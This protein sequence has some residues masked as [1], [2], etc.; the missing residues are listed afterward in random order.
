LNTG[1]SRS[2]V[3]VTGVHDNGSNAAASREQSR[4]ANFHGSSDDAVGC[5]QRG[6]SRTGDGLRQ[7]QVW[8]A[9]DLNTGGNG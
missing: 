3:G 5:E 9:A 7:R 6:G 2:A 4:A 1:L 8:P